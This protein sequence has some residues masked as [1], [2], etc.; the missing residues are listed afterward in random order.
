MNYLEFPVQASRDFGSWTGLVGLAYSPEQQALDRDNRYA[1][2]GLDHDGS[3]LPVAVSARLGK[4]DGAFASDKIDWS[5]TASRQLGQVQASASYVDSNQ[6][7]AALVVSL[8]L[9]F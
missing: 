7:S 5:L 2:L 9:K 3:G 4:E 1:W 8:G 6:S